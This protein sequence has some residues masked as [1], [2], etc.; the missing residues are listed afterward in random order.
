MF[1]DGASDDKEVMILHRTLKI[2]DDG[3]EYSAGRKH[4]QQIRAKYNIGSG[5]K[6]LDAPAEKEELPDGSEVSRDCR[7]RKLSVAGSDRLVICVERGVQTSV[8]SQG[9]WRGSHE[10]NGQGLAEVSEARLE[11]RSWQIACTRY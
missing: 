3:L 5:S 7:S 8:R 1:G 9:Q 6:G 2:I 4:E 10:M 11:I